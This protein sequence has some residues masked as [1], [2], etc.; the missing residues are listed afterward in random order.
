MV[1]ILAFEQA[2]TLFLLNFVKGSLII[3]GQEKFVNDLTLIIKVP[4]CTVI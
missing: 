1:T 4:H 2:R 3:S